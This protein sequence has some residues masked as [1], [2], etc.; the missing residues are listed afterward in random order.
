MTIFGTAKTQATL[1]FELPVAV[2]TYAGPTN[3]GA[4]A[5]LDE[6]TRAAA[7]LAILGLVLVGLALVLVAAV[8]G[9]WVRRV[10]QERVPHRS[11]SQSDWTPQ[12]SGAETAAGYPQS[13]HDATDTLHESPPD[14]TRAD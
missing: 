1:P 9:R 6:P 4:N 8:G 11:W 2:L 14:D 7:M 10:A 13:G 3:A 5:A 12:S